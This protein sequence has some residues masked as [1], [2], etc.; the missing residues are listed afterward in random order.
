MIN[1]NY[2]L[3]Q[4]LLKNK[5]QLKFLMKIQFL[6]LSFQ[7][8]NLIIQN[9][10]RCNKKWMQKTQKIESVCWRILNLEIFSQLSKN[11]K[12]YNPFMISILMKKTHKYKKQ[13]RIK[14]LINSFS[15]R[16]NYWGKSRLKS[17]IRKLIS[18]MRYRDRLIC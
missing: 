12:N 15:K 7:K 4:I 16:L 2:Q 3:N 6:I 5:F 17:Q 14:K 13:M 8:Q 18:L 1:Y 9:S 10:P 11:N